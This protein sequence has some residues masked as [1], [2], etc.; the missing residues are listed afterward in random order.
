MQSERSLKRKARRTYNDLVVL[1]AYILSYFKI[2]WQ[3]KSCTITK[4]AN[5]GSMDNPAALRCSKR[6]LGL[7]RDLGGGGAS[8]EHQSEGNF[9]PETS[10]K[11]AE[12][13]RFWVSKLRFLNFKSIESQIEWLASQLILKAN[14]SQ[15]NWI[16]KQK[17]LKFELEIIWISHHLNLKPVLESQVTWTLESQIN[18]W[19]SNHLK[20][21]SIDNQIAWLPNQL[22]TKSLGPQSSWIS[23]QLKLKW[24]GNK[25]LEPQTDGM[26]KQLNLKSL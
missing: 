9:W 14:D 20:L 11:L 18:D 16:S 6:H 24:T 15:T 7:C 13:L 12:K 17:N 26:S 23:N 4:D 8:C 25:T 10:L 5:P 1:C 3:T 19:Q 2:S 21:E 22:T